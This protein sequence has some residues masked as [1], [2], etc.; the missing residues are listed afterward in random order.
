MYFCYFVIIFPWKTAGS[1]FEQTEF[2]F[3]QGCLVPSLVEIGSLVLEKKM[4]M[5]KFYDNDANEDDG[6]RTN[7]DQKISPESSAQVS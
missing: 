7:L 2:P 1:S 6:Q 5:W 4:N 3:T